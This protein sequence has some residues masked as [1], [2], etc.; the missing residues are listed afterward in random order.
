MLQ[1]AEDREKFPPDA[2]KSYGL[3]AVVDGTSVAVEKEPDDTVFTWPHL[4]VREVAWAMFAV[5]ALH[6]VSTYLNAPLEEIADPGVT[7]N[8]AKA[9]WYF[10]GLQEMVS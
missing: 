8:P 4:V 2:D 5:L 6:L 1:R 3:M 9:P 10:L 7:P